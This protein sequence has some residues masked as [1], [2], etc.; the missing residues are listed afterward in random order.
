MH[1]L[2]NLKLCISRFFYLVVRAG[3]FHSTFKWKH[4]VGFMLNL[5]AYV[6]PYQQL[7]MMAKPTYSENGEFEDGG[8]D[9]TTDGVCG[10]RLSSLKS[11]D[12]PERPGRNPILFIG[13]YY[14]SDSNVTV[15]N[16]IPQSAMRDR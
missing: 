11:F 10:S 3:I 2:L 16:L 6:I 14:S 7:A 15:L 4:W 8:F 13:A 12:V 5:F 1:F 9:L